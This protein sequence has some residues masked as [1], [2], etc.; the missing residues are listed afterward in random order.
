[1]TWDIDEIVSAVSD[2]APCLIALAQAIRPDGDA[3]AFAWSNG[4]VMATVAADK[5]T[6]WRRFG[7]M[8]KSNKITLSLGD[9]ALLGAACTHWADERDSWAEYY[10]SGA[11]HP[12]GWGC[13]SIFYR[14]SGADSEPVMI[15]RRAMGRLKGQELQGRN[16]IRR[17]RMP[18]AVAIGV[19]ITARVYRMGEAV[20]PAEAL[21]GLLYELDGGLKLR[22]DRFHQQISRG[23]GCI[24]LEAG[25]EPV[26]GA[27]AEVLDRGRRTS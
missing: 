21:I 20:G 7:V 15:G 4:R 27:L 2:G 13:S 11:G 19:R 24:F 1:M 8:S 9:I 18:K 26:V 14:P 23:K 16:V 17:L 3:A 22:T 5:A 10:E 12:P 25:E 6:M